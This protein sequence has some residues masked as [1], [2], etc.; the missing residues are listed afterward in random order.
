[1]AIVIATEAHRQAFA[2]HL[3]DEGIDPAMAQPGPPAAGSGLVMLDAREAADSLLIDGRI[4]AHR[5][6]KLIGE[7]V[8]EAAAGGRPVRAYGEIVAVMWADGHVRAALELEEL[9]NGLGREVD[10]SLYCA[11][12]RHP[13][14]PRATPTAFHEVCRQHSAVV[15]A[16]A[17][18]EPPG[19]CP[20]EL[21]VDVPVERPGP[22]PGPPLRDRD[23]GRLGVPGPRSTTPP[24]SPPNWPPTPSSTPSSDFT[25]VLSRRPE[26]AIRIAVRDASLLQP[27]SGPVV[28]GPSTA[29]RPRPRSGGGDRRPVGAPTCPPTARW[30]GP[31]SRQPVPT[32]RPDPRPL[33]AS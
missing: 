21:E 5:F 29:V 13:V 30:C 32:R 2:A 3:A 31:S 18:L 33:T 24:S 22:G 17:A 14:G 16:P 7:L 11:Y 27:R 26:G 23:P 6:D 12:P 20:P 28:S 4:A 10:F 19:A 8:R 9:W 25:V 1:M 15:G